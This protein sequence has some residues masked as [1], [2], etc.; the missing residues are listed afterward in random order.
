MP[1]KKTP[2]M[3][4]ISRMIPIRAKTADDQVADVVAFAERRCFIPRDFG[5]V[6]HRVQQSLRIAAADRA[7]HHI[8][9]RSAAPHQERA[10]S[11]LL[12]ALQSAQPLTG[13]LRRRIVNAT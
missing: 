7:S 13:D 5:F 4:E 10:G 3:I 6:V 2:K 11:G 1:P 8:H 12:R 9:Q